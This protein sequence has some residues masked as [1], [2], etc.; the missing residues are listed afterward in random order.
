MGIIPLSKVPQ[1]L[2]KKN[3]FE[4]VMILQTGNFG[5]VGGKEKPVAGK[6]EGGKKDDWKNGADR[7]GGH[8]VKPRTR[9]PF[10][11]GVGHINPGKKKRQG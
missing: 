6:V 5:G 9:N 3:A 8:G 11:P 4:F 1:A 2:G 7:K 10:S